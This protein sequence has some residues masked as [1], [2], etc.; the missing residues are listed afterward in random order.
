MRS[1][2]LPNPDVRRYSQGFGQPFTSPPVFTPVPL[3]QQLV[4]RPRLW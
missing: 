3:P 4:E 2:G 1:P